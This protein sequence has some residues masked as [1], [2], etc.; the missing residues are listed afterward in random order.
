MTDPAASLGAPLSTH[1]DAVLVISRTEPRPVV[2]ARS[3]GT[4]QTLE[5]QVRYAEGDAILTGP[6]GEQWPV[7]RAR[8]D[9]AYLPLAPDGGGRDGLYQKQP[10]RCWALVLIGDRTVPLSSGRGSLK[11]KAG[12]VL[13]EYGPGDRSIVAADIFAALYSPAK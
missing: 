1:P 4:I 13:L 11:G 2:F 6:K 8:F 12:D 3:A 10:Q 9:A 7:A 5:G